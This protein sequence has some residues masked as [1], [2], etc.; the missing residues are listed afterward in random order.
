MNTAMEYTVDRVLPASLEAER[1]VLGA[2]LLDPKAYDEAAALG[3]TAG[4]MSCDSHRRIYSAMQAI[5]EAGRPIDIVT[6]PEELATRRQLEAVGDYGYISG[7]LDGVPDRP[8]IRHY[9]KIVRE[10]SAQR[11]LVHACN[12]T[13]GAI[14][15]GCS[16]QE[17]IE[18]LGE[19]VLQIQTGSDEA[20]A[21][22]V[23][24]FTD[25]VY[26]EWQK[27]ADGSGDLI[28]LSTSLDCLDLATTGIR[29]GELWLVGGRTG[30]GKTALSL[31]I[32]AANC[33]KEIPVAMFSIEMAKGDLLQR[34]WSHD[35]KIP[36]QCI[37]YPRR[38]E[39]DMR[40]RI[41]RAM[42]NVGQWPLFVVEDSSL[43]IQRLVAKARL[44]I[45][46]EKV[47]LLIVDYVQ[48][49]SAPAK[50][51]K[52]RLTKVS[53]A[54]RSLAK[55]TGVPV[56]A[57]SQLSRPKDGSL[58]ARPNKFHLKESG[59]QE[60]DSHVI[61]LT[62][63]PV[64]DFGNPTG[65]DELIIAKQRHGPVSNERVHF[66]SKTLTFYERHC[67]SRGEATR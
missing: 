43:S 45:R 7:L 63:R 25:L 47:Q 52:E 8:S 20:P 9:V 17:A 59:S 10:K 11:K 64:D 5:A 62:Y 39:P 50:D 54:L 40:K 29:R 48:L 58:N 23:V 57:I 21:Q 2:I 26:N 14:G 32:A 28:G 13:M 30:D 18:G 41:Q 42:G 44:L 65:D 4:D 53:N 35:G 46:Q 56:V 67:Q 36:F 15:T 49:I 51:E 37:R 61:I 16:S 60:N 12:A 34:L 38:L 33:R 1:S 19:S 22:R 6:L 27:L 66:D 55:D 31:Q 24:S 3:L